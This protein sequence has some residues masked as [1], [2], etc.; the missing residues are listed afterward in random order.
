MRLLSR[1]ARIL[2][3]ICMLAVLCKSGVSAE[4]QSS[5]ISNGQI[6]MI[7]NLPTLPESVEGH[8]FIVK[9]SK[10]HLPL[11]VPIEAAGLTHTQLK[12]KIVEAYK[13]SRMFGCV[14]IQIRNNR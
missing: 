5:G 4:F 13:Q 6:L 7:Q 2:L 11:I 14:D 10:V 12:L 1:L 8:P 3:P 9:D